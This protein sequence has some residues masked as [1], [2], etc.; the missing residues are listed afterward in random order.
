MADKSGSPAFTPPMN[1]VTDSDPQI[2]T[3]GRKTDVEWGFRKSQ[4]PKMTGEHTGPVRHI[5]NGS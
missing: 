2:V 1:S 5:S 4:D 3:V